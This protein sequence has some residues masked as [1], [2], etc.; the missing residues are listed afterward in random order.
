MAKTLIIFDSDTGKNEALAQKSKEVLES[1]NTQVR[2]RRVEPVFTSLDAKEKHY[3]SVIPIINEEDLQWAEGYIITCP[4]H[5]GTISASIKYFFD[6]YHGLAGRGL[7]LNKP[8]T[9]MTIGKLAHAGAETTIQQLYTILMQWGTL[10]VPSSIAYPEILHAN[11]NPYG[12]SFILD[13]TNS[14]GNDKLWTEVLRL[15]FQRFTQIVDAT[16]GLIS[17]D[18]IHGKSH[19]PYT[20]T[21]ALG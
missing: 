12:L 16:K 8:A 9:A 18:G 13:A 20:I 21:G 3:N 1:L 2:I 7:F 6:K 10:I 5:T 19:L 17:S 15:H 4:I 11:G 14:F